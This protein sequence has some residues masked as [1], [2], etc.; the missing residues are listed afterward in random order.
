MTGVTTQVNGS[1]GH[2]RRRGHPD[3]AG[4]A[5]S[6]SSLLADL[7]AAEV[8]RRQQLREITTMRRDIY[9]AAKEQGIQPS[10]LRAVHTMLRGKGVT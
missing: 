9:A 6:F 8:L 10:V 5:R 1:N 4:L 2:T 3:D 7:S